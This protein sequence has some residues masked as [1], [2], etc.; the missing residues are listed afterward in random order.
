MIIESEKDIFKV[1]AQALVNPVNTVGVMGKGLAL[2]FKNKFPIMFESYKNACL[3]KTISIGKNHVWENSY[4]SLP[5]YIINFPTKIH[6]K[7]DSQYENIDLGL[8]NLKLIMMNLHITSMAI[9]CLGCGLGGLESD[10]IREKIK[11]FFHTE[12]KKKNIMIFIL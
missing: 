1:K 10:V 3:N 4:N 7:C 5:Q 9:P 6:W 8:L 12:I 2:E 11:Q